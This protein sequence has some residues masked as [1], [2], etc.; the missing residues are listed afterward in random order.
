MNNNPTI[1]PEF[2]P[3]PFTRF[4]MTIG[5]IPTSY[6]DSLNYMEQVL[7]LIK[8]LE[9][10]VI[11]AVDN[12]AAA[13]EELQGLY[14]QL[15]E[16]VDHYFDS[17]N[18]QE[19]VNDKLDEMVEDG[20]LE[21]LINQTLLNTKLD[22]YIIDNSMTL[23]DIQAILDINRPKVIL[24]T[25][26]TYT[27]NNFL[28]INENTTLLLNKS[29]IN[30]TQNL[31]HGFR[32]FKV[33]ETPV[34]YNGNGNIK[35]IGGTT[36]GAMLLCHAK[37]I[38]I[39]DVIFTGDNM[40]EHI[41]QLCA[42]K[43]IKIDK[44]VFNGNY[45]GNTNFREVIQLDDMR[46]ENFPYFN[47][48]ITPYDNTIDDGVYISN[49]TF[50]NPNTE[51]VTLL[52]CIGNHSFNGYHNSNIYID[53]CN[54]NNWKYA[55]IRITG[56]K[57]VNIDNCQFNNTQVNEHHVC[58]FINN[59]VELLNITNCEFNGMMKIASSNST[60]V[61][62][63]VR[64]DNNIF[65]NQ[66]LPR[67]NETPY[68]G[69]YGQ[70]L[71]QLNYLDGTNYINNN[72]INNCEWFFIYLSPQYSTDAILYIDNNMINNTDCL[73]ICYLHSNNHYVVTNNIFKMDNYLAVENVNNYYF[74]VSATTIQSFIEKNNIFNSAR[75]SVSIPD[76]IRFSVT[77]M[78]TLKYF[79]TPL[80]LNNDKN[81]SVSNL[82][83]NHNI[84]DFNRLL[85]KVGTTSA[86]LAYIKVYP[87]TY[88]NNKLTPGT[89]YLNCS[90]ASDT[91]LTIEFT[92][93]VDGTVSY[94]TNNS[95][96]K[97]NGLY[98]LNE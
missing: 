42:L 37:D 20:T 85:I 49:C 31:Y 92:I 94:N 52:T 56:W 78:P 9:S 87:L 5:Y 72:K 35:I 33:T 19:M 38:L 96:Y 57:N 59:N 51:S 65:N 10:K 73:G 23:S 83:L 4:C 75:T 45:L 17:T 6:L 64:I 81:V 24:F 46:Y 32:N 60:S 79:S 77:N 40:P 90:V 41:L 30:F 28:E 93:N 91:M 63:D 14:I 27:F 47:D 58:I 68:V 50:N 18:F 69:T 82:S 88:P 11:P 39:Q 12:N 29:T 36:N 67:E 70:G 97:V 54:F 66:I 16:Y 7:W 43:N 74:M 86:N 95:S 34:L 22:C 53:N 13:V 2:V 89:Y 84:F 15:K 55:A 26:G 44:C 48:T 25:T 1:K 62:K 71:I 61:V 80:L 98:G 76:F 21:T 3:N 8:F